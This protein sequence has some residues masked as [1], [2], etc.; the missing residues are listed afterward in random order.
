MVGMV[1]IVRPV[2]ACRVGMKGVFLS[3][4]DGRSAEGAE[5]AALP[6]FS[7]LC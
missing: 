7:C 5:K 2:V 4:L 6:S 3:A 1:F